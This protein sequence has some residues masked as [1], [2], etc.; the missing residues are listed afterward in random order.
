MLKP[1][2]RRRVPQP[3]VT[4]SLRLDEETYTAVSRVADREGRSVNNWVVRLL[5]LHPEVQDALSS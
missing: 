2:P 4:I 1:S 3:K 5:T